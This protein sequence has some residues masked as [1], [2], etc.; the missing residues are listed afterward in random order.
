MRLYSSDVRV[1]RENGD[2]DPSQI[3]ITQNDITSESERYKK[4]RNSRSFEA[5]W[6]NAHQH[7]PNFFFKAHL[8]SV[9]VPF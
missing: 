7:S 6:F 4:R 1:F 8:A 3:K 9:D 2:G 5:Y